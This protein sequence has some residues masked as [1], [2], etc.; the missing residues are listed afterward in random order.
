MMQRIILNGYLN[1]IKKKLPKV[2]HKKSFQ[3][4]SRVVTYNGLPAAR[5]TTVGAGAFCI[6]HYGS[7]GLIIINM[8][9]N[10]P[11]YVAP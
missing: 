6:F 11:L 2:F 10:T 4:L 8:A 9:L 1:E 5:L 3:N 7:N